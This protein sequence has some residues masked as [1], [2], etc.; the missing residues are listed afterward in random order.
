MFGG[1]LVSRSARPGIV[2]PRISLAAVTF[3]A[4]VSGAAVA[5]LVLPVAVPSR[6]PF[7]VAPV[8]LAQDQDPILEFLNAAVAADDKVVTA[9]GPIVR[10]EDP[11]GDVVGMDATG[12]DIVSAG[13][14]WLPIVPS[15]VLDGGFPCGAKTTACM[16]TG[17]TDRYGA[18]AWI[19]HGRRA[20]AYGGLGPTV[21]IEFGPQLVLDRYPTAPQQAGNAFSGTSHDI[22]TRIEPG[23]RSVTYFAFANGTFSQFNTE[24]RST[25]DATDWYTIVPQSEE[26][27]TAP[28]AWDVYSYFSD[29]TSAG[30][31]RDTLRGLDGGAMLDWTNPPSLEFVDAPPSTE[32]TTEP[33]TEPTTGLSG[34]PS[35]S[36][37]ASQRASGEPS[38]EPSGSPAAGPSAGPSASPGTGEGGGPGGFQEILSQPVVLI[39]LG[40]GLAVLALWLIFGRGRGSKTQEPPIEPFRPKSA[41]RGSAP[42]ESPEPPTESPEPPTASPEPPPSE[43]A[44]PPMPESPEPGPESPPPEPPDPGREP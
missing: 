43:A 41:P 27:L 44:T 18:G 20:G 33:S 23:Q 17:G 24:A 6:V 21:T 14:A 4:A 10:V 22:I 40:I 26:I 16:G 11:T 35:A 37:A 42:P 3:I 39:A 36:A 19:F 2:S 1:S 15:S 34:E 12:N 32:P 29:G 25:W 28:R 8:V 9:S 13:Y 31:G 7:A 30:T 5:V 38:M